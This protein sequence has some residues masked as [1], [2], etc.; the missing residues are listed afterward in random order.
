[1]SLGWYELVVFSKAQIPREQFP[2]NFLVAN[3]AKKLW[4]FAM[5]L[6]VSLVRRGCYEDASDFQ[7]ILI[8]HGGLEY[9]RNVCMQLVLVGLVELSWHSTTPTSTRTSSRAS[10]PARPT[11]AILWSHSYGKL[12]DTP[13]FLRRCRCRCRRRGMPFLGERQDKLPQQ[14]PAANV[15]RKLTTCRTCR[16]CR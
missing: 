14:M 9:R 13:T 7:T 6:G 8:C 3:V 1:M 15:T 12:N 2:R 10:S 11:R 4:L 5:K 16:E